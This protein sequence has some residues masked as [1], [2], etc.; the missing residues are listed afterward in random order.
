[1]VAERM[2]ILD[3]VKAAKLQAQSS[4]SPVYNVLY[5]YKTENSISKLL[6]PVFQD[7]VVDVGE[8]NLWV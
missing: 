8:H 4:K 7:N 2:I 3:A 5:N 6:P 1:M